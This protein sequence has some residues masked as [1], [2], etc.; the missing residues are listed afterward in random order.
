MPGRYSA[1]VGFADGAKISRWAALRSRRAFAASS[2]RACLPP[3]TG[4][5]RDLLVDR[6]QVMFMSPSVPTGRSPPSAR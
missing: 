3:S 1:D 5:R 4:T 2:P 6:Q